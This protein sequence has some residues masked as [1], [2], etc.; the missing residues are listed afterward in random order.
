M[1]AFAFQVNGASDMLWLLTIARKAAG[2]GG[3]YP[4]STAAALESS[5]EHFD[6][7]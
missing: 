6:Y 5:N 7:R 3:G 4:T 2:V 1:A